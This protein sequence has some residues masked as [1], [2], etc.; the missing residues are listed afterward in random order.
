MD[1][2]K[3][4]EMAKLLNQKADTKVRGLAYYSIC[5]KMGHEF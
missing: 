3:L 2:K 1:A 5:F 4:Y